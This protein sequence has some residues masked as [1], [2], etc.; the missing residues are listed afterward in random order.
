MG[1]TYDVHP[2]IAVIP[3]EVEGPAFP[4]ATL[5][6]MPLVRT[7]AAAPFAFTLAALSQAPATFNS[8][9]PNPDRSLTFR[10]Q[11]PTATAVV[12]N[13]D[14]AA[15][16]VPMLK[17]ADGLWTYTTPPLPPEIYSYRFD[18]DSRPQFDPNNLTGI[19]PNLV[20]RGDQVEVPGDTPQLWDLQPVPHGT[21]HE[22]RYTTK[23][24]VGLPAN[25]SRFLVYTPPGYDPRARIAYPVLYL[26]HG[27]SNTVDTWT[28]TLQADLILDNLL[29]SGKI[30][31]MVVVIPLAYGDMSFVNGPI[32]EIWKQKPLVEHNTELFSQALLTEILPQAESAYTIRRDRQ[33]RALA[34]LSMGGLESLQIG[35]ANTDKFAFL[36]GFSAAVHLIDPPT[37]F[38]TLTPKSTDLRLLW[39]AC[40]VDDGL[41]KANQTLAA[42]L[43]SQG[44]PVT[45]VETPGAHVAFVWRDNL[46]H[47]APLLF[48]TI[49][50]SSQSK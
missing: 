30:K 36:G 14:T 35:L 16:P 21:L 17:G 3:T 9:Q 34:G 33:G 7:L 5:L 43:K 24:V 25:Q 40:G 19:T 8:H 18:V 39:I 44:L 22:H 50:P 6:L 12:L 29:A 46:I 20:Y 13:L 27:W 10:Y 4:S 45:E 48:Q 26:L 49:P 31:P 37:Q 28:S 11:D 32:G 47:F 23:A 42:Y 41:L 1:R 15:K 2:P 38:S